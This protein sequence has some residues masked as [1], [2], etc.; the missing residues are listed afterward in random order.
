MALE[1]DIAALSQ[2]ELF[3]LF[4][5]EA[6]KL[7]AFAAEA[8]AL[9]AGDV[10]FRK[11]DRA[12]GGYVVRSGN[13]VLA[14]DDNKAEPFI[15]GPGTLI[16]RMALFLRNARPATATASEPS[17]VIRISPTLMR[18]TLEEFP[19]CA[20]IVHDALAQD[21]LDLTSG[22]EDVRMKFMNDENDG[23]P[24]PDTGSS[25]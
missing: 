11:G 12:D 3:G 10:L 18:R 25:A 6:L 1:D 2:A 24:E 13:I 22:L 20:C 16:G 21:L 7:L 9:K 8:R 4:E 17:T 15:A 23:K 14:S 19:D 5:P